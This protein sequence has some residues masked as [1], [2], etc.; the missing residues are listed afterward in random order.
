MKAQ[1]VASIAVGLAVAAVMFLPLVV[2]QYRRFGR[3]D[4][5]RIAWT[6]AGFVYAAG[7]VAFTIFPLPD[8]SGDF[9]VASA[10]QPVWDPLRFPRAALDILRDKGPVALA[11]DFLVWE[12]AMNMVLFIPFGL[13]VRRVL[14][15]PRRTVLAAGLSTSILIEL[16]QMT[17]NWFLAPCPYRYA[18]TTD[19]FTNTIG[20]GIG[21]GLETL[22]PR[23][24]S[25]KRHLLAQRDSARPVTPMR[26][27]LGMALDFWYLLTAALAGGTIGSVGYTV[28]RRGQGVLTET[29]MFALERAILTSAWA[30]TL[31]VALVPALVSTGASLGQRTVY[32][33][34]DGPG[35]SR[36]RCL[37]R[38]AIVQA[39]VPTMLYLGL[40]WA[41]GA[42][43]L[44]LAA[45]LCAVPDPRGLSYRTA[46][47]DITDARTPQ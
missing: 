23:L 10:T 22:T 27:L 9:C 14:E 47:L 45:L 44:A 33:R 26:R 20:T 37:L 41:L 31:I 11:G 36:P 43:V 15:W 19:L 5:L 17:G 1:I 16:T 6:A 40:P 38:A 25:T 24:L 35:R 28:A 42:P 18:D 12:F 32:L 30:G 46:G 29:Q 34:P 3:F 13:M 21:I 7:L 4:P 8:F 39:A 2:W